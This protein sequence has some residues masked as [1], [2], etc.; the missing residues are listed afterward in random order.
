[1]LGN[2]AI[3]VLF[4]SSLAYEFGLTALWLPWIA[5]AVLLSATIGTGALLYADRKSRRSAQVAA[6]AEQESPEQKHRADLATALL[7]LSLP[8]L[9]WLTN[10]GVLPRLLAATIAVV[11]FT[12]Y[13]YFVLVKDRSRA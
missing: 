12:G 5:G 9:L 7:L 2:V 10:A 3:L 11:V 13:T 1:V 8:A 4:G 6:P